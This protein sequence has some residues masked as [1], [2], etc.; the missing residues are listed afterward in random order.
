MQVGGSAAAP[1]IEEMGKYL[2]DNF[3]PAVLRDPLG[4]HE[5][6]NT[7]K[8][9]TRLLPP[10]LDASGLHGF[11]YTRY[12]EI[13]AVMEPD[14]IHPEIREKLDAICRAFNIPL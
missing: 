12:H 9:R 10:I 11:P 3:P 8:A 7:T 6:M 2:N 14:E 4:N 5:F 1:Y 13:A